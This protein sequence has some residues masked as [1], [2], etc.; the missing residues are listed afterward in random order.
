V[1]VMAQL[2]PESKGVNGYSMPSQVALFV[3]PMLRLLMVSDG[4]L[5]ELGFTPQNPKRRDSAQGRS[6][7]SC[8]SASHQLRSTR[9][10]GRTIALI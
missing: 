7:L 4:T 5:P 8:E 10:A 6:L 2:E 1:N 9:T 3:G